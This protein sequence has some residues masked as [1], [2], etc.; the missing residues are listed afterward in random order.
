[1]F[2]GTFCKHYPVDTVSDTNLIQL[3]FTY[4]I[5]EHQNYIIRKLQPKEIHPALLNSFSHSQKLTKNGLSK[6]KNGS[7]QMFLSCVNGV[8]RSGFG[9]Q[10][11]CV[12][13]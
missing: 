6:M 2:S 11:I 8:R 1:M 4:M 5:K 12:N 7:L 13:K 10:S 3:F 9:L